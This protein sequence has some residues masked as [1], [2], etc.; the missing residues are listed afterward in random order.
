MGCLLD[1]PP[2]FFTIAACIFLLSMCTLEKL[3]TQ[4]LCQSPGY[5]C[6]IFNQTCIEIQ[7][8]LMANGYGWCVSNSMCSGKHRAAG[9]VSF[10]LTLSFRV[11][12]KENLFTSADRISLLPQF[13]ILFFYQFQLIRL[14]F[15]K[16]NNS[17][18]LLP[19]KSQGPLLLIII[20]IIIVLCSS[21]INGRVL[22]HLVWQE[23]LSVPNCANRQC[24]ARWLPVKWCKRILETQICRV[25]TDRWGTAV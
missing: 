15:V 18:C 12:S 10:C 6:S 1:W 16:W 8:I 22:L 4:T 20:I 7:C 19:L 23:L 24:C 14:D 11:R 9:D 2:P 25:Q 3:L 17:L 13:Y 5:K 21:L